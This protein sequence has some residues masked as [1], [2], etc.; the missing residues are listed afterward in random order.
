MCPGLRELD[1][2]VGYYTPHL[3]IYELMDPDAAGEILIKYIYITYPLTSHEDIYVQ[4]E[5]GLPVYW[6]IAYIDEF[7]A[8]Q[9]AAI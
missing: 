5:R 3:S 6:P 8:R 1:S 2:G 4:G 9:G 7:S